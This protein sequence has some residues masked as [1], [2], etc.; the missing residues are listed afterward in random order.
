MT[1][2]TEEK[3]DRD[4]APRPRLLAFKCSS[5]LENANE[6]K[7]SRRKQIIIIPVL[8]LLP[9]PRSSSSSD[10]DEDST[11]AQTKHTAGG[12]GGGPWR[13]KL[14]RL[15]TDGSWDDRGTGR[16]MCS[17]S[18][19]PTTNSNQ[20]ET[21]NKSLQ[22]QLGDPTLVLKSEQGHD[23]LLQSRVLLREAYQRQGDNII[24][25]CEPYFPEG[26]EKQSTTNNI[27]E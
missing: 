19:P 11:L 16:I 27:L 14:Y 8:W 4:K 21:T 9:P 17:Y 13:V 18:Y 25:W 7:P 23:I 10:E 15:N 22:H 5:D 6:P 3:H 12:A 2:N 20:K 24:T 1:N 26:H